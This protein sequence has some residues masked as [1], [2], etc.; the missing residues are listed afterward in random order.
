MNNSTLTQK[1]LVAGLVTAICISAGAFD[2]FSAFI[3]TNIA[4]TPDGA[5]G[6]GYG[7]DSVS[8]YGQ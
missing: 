6:F 4:G 3:R 1:C 5:C 8:G 7:Y 2:V